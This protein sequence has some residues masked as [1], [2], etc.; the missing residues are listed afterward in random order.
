MQFQLGLPSLLRC[1]LCLFVLTSLADSTYARTSF[2][3][4]ELYPGPWLEVT[5]EVRDFLADQKISSC[6]EAAARQSSHDPGEY[7]LYCTEDET[8][9][10]SWRV[11]P[12]THMLHGP[13]KLLDGIPAPGN[14]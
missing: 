14:Y 2:S 9:W 7:L 8:H 5:Q 6:N 12:A 3:P 13:G 11:R 4:S 10:T 1:G